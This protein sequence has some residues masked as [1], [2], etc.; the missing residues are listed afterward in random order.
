MTCG[1]HLVHPFAAGGRIFTWVMVGTR[2]CPYKHAEAIWLQLWYTVG[3][4]SVIGNEPRKE[5][6]K[7]TQRAENRMSEK[8]QEERPTA[9]VGDTAFRQAK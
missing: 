4:I 7:L 1:Q 5:P 9:Y 8:K 6:P 2:L 3:N